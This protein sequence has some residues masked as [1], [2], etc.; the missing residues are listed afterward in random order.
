MSLDAVVQAAGLPGFVLGGFVEGDAVVFL[1]GI[2]AHKGIFRFEQVV[3]AVSLGAVLVDNLL[4]LL[5]RY[6]GRWPLV[7]RLLDHRAVQGVHGQLRRR[8]VLAIVGFRFLY[9]LKTAA[10]VLIGTT[11]VPWL[12]FAV[13]DLIGVLA[14]AH[15]VAGLGY[16]AGTAIE[17]A[18]GALQLQRHLALAL[19][20]CVVGLTAAWV[21]VRRKER[22]RV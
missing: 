13:L 14:W 17:A 9:G 6:A 10:A 21:L 16:G 5:G 3:L 11:P 15:V 20:V 8:P 19:V 1:G 22:A 2:L 12:R 18:F 4:F 7:Q